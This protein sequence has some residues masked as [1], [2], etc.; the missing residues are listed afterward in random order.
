MDIKDIDW[1]LISFV[2]LTLTTEHWLFIHRPA[3]YYWDTGTG[4][5]SHSRRK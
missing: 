2:W 3:L 5:S 4:F 1:R